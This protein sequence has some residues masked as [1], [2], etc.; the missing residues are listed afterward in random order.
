MNPFIIEVSGLTF[1]YPGFRALNHVTFSIAPGTVTA[2]VGPNGAGKTTL[3]R[4]IAALETPL[5]G[6]VRVAGIDVHEFPREVHRLMGY[7]SDSF[8]LY[9]D[10]TV[11]QG[12]FYAA[13]SQGLAPKAVDEAVQTTARRM[14]LGDKLSH[15]ASTLS[16]GQRQRLAI[17]QAI[18]HAPQVL[19]LDEPASGLD[20]EARSALADVFLALKAQGM[21]LLVSSHILAELDAYC[22]HMLALNNGQVLEHRALS[23]VTAEGAGHFAERRL[24]LEFC[25][26]AEE[27]VSLW[28]QSQPGVRLVG[29][30]GQ[31]LEIG[32]T[33]SSRAQ[34]ALVAACVGAGHPLTSI[35]LITENLQQSYLKSLQA[36]RHVASSHE[37]TP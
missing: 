3:L 28:V 15:M 2:L 16:R 1:D 17:G 13:R 6:T 7:L 19:L 10:L 30:Q 24:R 21:S 22:T 32:F 27:Q 23:P 26:P 9:S 20:P 11:A 12:L 18:I 36:Q 29:A 14:G 35:A 33:G 34:A 8:G 31:A 37:V 4:C 25:T 5:S